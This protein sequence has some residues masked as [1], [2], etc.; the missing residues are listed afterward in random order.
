[1]YLKKKIVALSH[2]QTHTQRKRERK[3]ETQVHR[4]KYVP[5]FRKKL[6]IKSRIYYTI[7]ITA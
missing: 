2:T 3:R 6:H 7:R 4:H 5:D 1:M